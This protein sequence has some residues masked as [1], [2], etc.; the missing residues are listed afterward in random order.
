MPGCE[1]EPSGDQGSNYF[2]NVLAGRTIFYGGSETF[3]EDGVR[4]TR[5]ISA[6]EVRESEIRRTQK[7]L[8]LEGQNS[9]L[10]L[11]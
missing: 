10:S 5:K 1:W 7:A 11:Q 6:D 4:K 9:D 3:Y 2:R 8:G